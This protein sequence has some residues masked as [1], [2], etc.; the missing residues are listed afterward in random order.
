MTLSQINGNKSA[1]VVRPMTGKAGRA[2]YLP[3]MVDNIQI[4][5]IVVVLTLLALGTLPTKG[6]LLACSRTLVLVPNHVDEL[7]L[8]DLY[9]P[10]DHARKSDNLDLSTVGA[11]LAHLCHVCCESCLWARVDR[12]VDEGNELVP[13]IEKE[14]ANLVADGDVVVW[15]AV[16]LVREGSKQA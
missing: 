4:R 16:E 11:G 9:S 8:D 7:G 3:I 5:Q 2:P 10:A 13:V 6:A 14:V 15:V 12:V 1:I